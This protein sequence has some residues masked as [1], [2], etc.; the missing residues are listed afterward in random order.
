MDTILNPW[1]VARGELLGIPA[2]I[3]Q[4]AH[5]ILGDGFGA[6]TL[7]L[8]LLAQGDL[9]AGAMLLSGQEVQV[10]MQPSDGDLATRGLCLETGQ[11]VVM[12]LQVR[13]GS[14]IAVGMVHRPDCFVNQVAQGTI[15][16]VRKLVEG[17][18]ELSLHTSPVVY[19]QDVSKQQPPL[20]VHTA[21][22]A[23]QELDDVEKEAP[24]R[25]TVC[26]LAV[27][28]KRPTGIAEL[29]SVQQVGACAAGLTLQPIQTGLVQ[30]ASVTTL[31]LECPRHA[32]IYP[33]MK[34]VRYL[35][36]SGTSGAWDLRPYP[37]HD[38]LAQPLFVLAVL[39]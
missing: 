11:P 24:G 21:V 35:E 5:E 19:L 3:C 2:T 28:G 34:G 10:I 20:P 15:I 4:A 18:V 32:V 30:S 29:L 25:H 22:D 13:S 6:H 23:A 38:A 8:H 31:L 37:H 33:A 36:D 26:K 27:A 17:D 7:L 12:T 16:H 1:H 9:E 39:C 14:L